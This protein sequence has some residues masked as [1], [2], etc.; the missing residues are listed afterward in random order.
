MMV[1]NHPGLIIVEGV[2]ER[3]GAGPRVL[4]G[5]ARAR[6]FISISDESNLDR[7]ARLIGPPVGETKRKSRSTAAQHT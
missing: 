2:G 1:G 3:E 4:L 6:R 5:L 7:C